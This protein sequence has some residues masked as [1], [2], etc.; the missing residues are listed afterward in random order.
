MDGEKILPSGVDVP[1]PSTVE[2]MKELEAGKGKRFTD[3][4]ELFEDIGA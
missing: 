3:A 2:A 1:N 4:D